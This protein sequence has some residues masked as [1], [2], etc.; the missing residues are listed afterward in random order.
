MICGIAAMTEDRVIGLN[1]QLPF[2]ISDD[3]KWFRKQTWGD[4]VLMGY[5]TYDYLPNAH[6]EGRKLYVL[7]RNEEY[8]GKNYEGVIFCDNGYKIIKRH[9]KYYK[10]LWIA[11][12]ASIYEQF[13][14]YCDYFYL[15]L[16]KRRYEGDSFM[17]SFE[18]YFMDPEIIYENGELVRL[19][20]TALPF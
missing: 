12:G 15:T 9:R 17:P 8:Y 16:V 19:K 6:L 1:G 2:Y 3:L 4:S 20:F 13:V 14:Q 7:T 10:Q 18:E 5:K 11:G